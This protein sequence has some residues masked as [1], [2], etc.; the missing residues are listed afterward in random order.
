MVVQTCVHLE[1]ATDLKE[2]KIEKMKDCSSD[3][4]TTCGASLCM[5]ALAISYTLK[6]RFLLLIVQ[7]H[8]TFTIEMRA[9]STKLQ[10]RIVGNNIIIL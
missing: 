3:L 7:D 5:T 1:C 6:D 4:A 10:A 9:C 8:N 2:S